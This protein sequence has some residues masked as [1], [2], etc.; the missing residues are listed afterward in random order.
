MSESR[1]SLLHRVADLGDAAMWREFDA[2]YRPLLVRYAQA[3]GA[4][5]ATADTLAQECLIALSRPLARLERR[6]SVRAYLRA[7]VDHK[8]C[9]V[10]AANRQAGDADEK[11]LA[12]LRDPSPIPSEPWARHWNEGIGRIVARRLRESFTPTTLRAFDLYVLEQRPVGEICESLELTANQ[13][14]VAKSRV[15]RFLRE[16]CADL[17]ESLYGVWS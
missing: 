2:V 15:A 1:G 8:L 13:V 7:V 5:P 14:F 9:G 4:D 6:R 11:T 12:E 10:L 16:E 3:R 17:I